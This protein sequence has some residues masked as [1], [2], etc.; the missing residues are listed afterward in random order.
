MGLRTS[1]NIVNSYV[2]YTWDGDTL[3]SQQ[4]SNNL[5]VFL[6][7]EN[8]SPVGL[9][10]RTA[11][12]AENAYHTFFF[13]K[14]LQGDI[15]AVYNSSGTK[16][17]SY[18]YDAWGNH[19][20]TVHSTNATESLVAQYNP[21]RYR[22]YYYDNET[23]WYYL[24]T[25]YYDPNTGRF[26][27]A[28]KATVIS[29]TPDQLTDKNLYAYCDNNPV[30]RTDNG[31]E[32][33]NWLVGGVVGAIG[34]AISAAIEGK[35]G[36]EFWGSVANGA[37]SGTIAGL[38][39]DVLVCTGGSAAV[40]LAVGAAASG[41]GSAVGSFA[42]DMMV[43][44]KANWI[45]IGKDAMFGTVTGAMFG[46]MSKGAGS[47]MKEVTKGASKK[48]LQRGISM[49]YAIKKTMIKELRDIGGS[50]IEEGLSNFTSWYLQRNIEN[51]LGW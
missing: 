48:A 13:E 3:I 27:N 24:Q 16:I 28:D 20:V 50:L 17:C 18:V 2:Y 49:G 10:Y 51:R 41:F 14:N 1:K 35:T 30:M 43:D 38:A 33:W 42:E 37:I 9:Q 47:M 8:G 29:A 5:F 32:F 45:D 23:G 46:S 22:G 31:G 39:V 25:R 21:F 7:D 12:L 15:I 40:F 6:Y 19:T 11:D 36:V 34:G 26:L 4:W 44:G